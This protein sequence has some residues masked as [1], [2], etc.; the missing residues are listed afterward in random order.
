MIMTSIRTNINFFFLCKI[1][2]TRFDFTGVGNS[3]MSFIIFFIVIFSFISVS[4]WLDA[5]KKIFYGWGGF[6]EECPGDALFLALLMTF[7]IIGA[8]TLMKQD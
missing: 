3:D 1:A 5:I 8:V 7:F 2:E 6:S 4:L